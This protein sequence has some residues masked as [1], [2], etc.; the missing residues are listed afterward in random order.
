MNGGEVVAMAVLATGGHG[1]TIA[2]TEKIRLDLEKKFGVESFNQFVQE[3]GLYGDNYQSPTE[4]EDYALL[5]AAS[6]DE[7]RD[8]IAEAR[9]EGRS[10]VLPGS[11][12]GHQGD[13]GSQKIIT[14]DNYNILFS[15][16]Y[17]EI[18]FQMAR[19][20][21]KPKALRYDTWQD[22]LRSDIFAELRI[23]SLAS[24]YIYF[25]I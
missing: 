7:A 3:E 8:R 18:L 2:L 19:E 16:K 10:G 13:A 9:Q 6:L 1:E 14:T 22:W 25:Q 12:Q 5:R 20:D 11:L 4:P 15:L 23:Y 24:F 17:Y 21:I